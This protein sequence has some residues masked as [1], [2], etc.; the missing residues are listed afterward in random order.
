MV[1]GISGWFVVC[2]GDGVDNKFVVVRDKTNGQLELQGSM[3]HDELGDM[4]HLV[5]MKK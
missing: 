4:K 1:G 2:I 5:P 3:R